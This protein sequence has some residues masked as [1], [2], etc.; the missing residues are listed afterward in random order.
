M[1]S[2]R[3]NESRLGSAA[4]AL[5]AVAPLAPVAVSLH[6]YT[7]SGWTWPP[8]TPCHLMLFTEPG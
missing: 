6:A 4:T 3:A 7:P 2:W 1:W 5:R 8:A